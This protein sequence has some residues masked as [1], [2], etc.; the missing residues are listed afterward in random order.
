MSGQ[1]LSRLEHQIGRLLRIGVVLSGSALGLGLALSLAGVAASAALIRAGLVLLMAIP[2]VRILASFVDA[3]R[4]RDRLLAWS[5]AFV[6]S[7]ML[8]TWLYSHRAP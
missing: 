4:R 3:V 7:V 5:T 6:L 2:V 1:D 8:A